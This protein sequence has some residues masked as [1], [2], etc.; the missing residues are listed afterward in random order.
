MLPAIDASPAK[1]ACRYQSGRATT[2]ALTASRSEAGARVR[3][4]GCTSPAKWHLAQWH[5]AQWHLAHTRW[6]F[7]TRVLETAEP[8]FRRHPPAYR[9]LF[10]SDDKGIG[11]QAAPAQ[12]GPVTRPRSQ[13]RA[14]CRNFFA[15]AARGQFSGLPL[16]C[17]RS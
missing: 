4:M 9:V 11:D 12:R 16:A 3:R 1:L 6:C 10:N 13:L 17:Y 8:D 14:V 5:L 2:L 15:A 7:E